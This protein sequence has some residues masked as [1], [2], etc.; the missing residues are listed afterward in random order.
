MQALY[1]NLGVV[2]D[3]R[4]RSAAKNR[5]SVYGGMKS[6]RRDTKK[7]AFGKAH[8]TNQWGG[9]VL[10]IRSQCA[11]CG[12]KKSKDGTALKRCSG[13]QMVWFCGAVCQRAAWKNHKQ[14]CKS[15]SGKKSSTTSSK[16]RSK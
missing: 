9:E 5:A 11:A 3:M 12:A 16:K 8:T 6:Q 1:G 13:C 2:L 15:T 7:K 14:V 10:K 4:H